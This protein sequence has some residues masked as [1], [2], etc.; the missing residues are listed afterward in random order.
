[1]RLIGAKIDIPL[2][3][4]F[5]SLACFC[6]KRNTVHSREELSLKTKIK[7][8]QGV[9]FFFPRKNACVLMHILLQMC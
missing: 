3:F 9:I 6:F 1:M 8:L 2:V 4:I 5:Q 7:N